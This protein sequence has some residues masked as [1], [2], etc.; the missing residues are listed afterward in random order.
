MAVAEGITLDKI[1]LVVGVTGH[2]NI[3][4]ADE[5]PLR[6]AFGGILAELAERYPHTPLLVLSGLAAGADVLAAEEAL[7]RGI[8]VIAC[9]PM[10][11][12][13]YENDFN[14]AERERFRAILPRCA[15]KPVV[16]Q[17]GDRRSGYVA[18]GLFITRYSHVLVAFWDGLEGRGRGGTADVVQTRLT[19]ESAQPDG[20]AVIPYLPDVGPVYHI[21]T[22]HDGVDRPADSFAVHRLY[23]RKFGDDLTVARDFEAALAHLDTYDADLGRAPDTRTATLHALHERTD[24]VAN[25]LQKRTN[26][27]LGLLYIILFFAATA[28]ITTENLAYK[29]FGILVT[30]G[31]YFLARKNDYE[32]RY[33]DYRALAEGLRVQEAWYCGGLRNELVDVFYL[34]M[35]QSEL[36]W[37]RMALR[38]AFLLFCEPGVAPAEAPDP[39]VCEDWVSGQ[40]EYF[41]FK[42][43]DQ[44]ARHK[45]L[46]T[47]STVALVAGGAISLAAFIAYVVH[48]HYTLAGAFWDPNNPFWDQNWAWSV[49]RLMTVPLPLAALV[50]TLLWQYGE[51]RNYAAN[52]RRYQRMYIVFERASE[53]LE[54]IGARDTPEALAVI[55]D[56]GEEALIEHADWLLA[57]RDR[58]LS[59]AHA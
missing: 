6:A 11:V 43:R 56:L 50:S 40:V 57:R 23:P 55:H 1:P 27:F 21:V 34:R 49:G 35:Q 3:A 9:L 48:G 36:Q 2:R 10:D 33:Q 59:L 4:S 16:S 52:A 20:V 25:T 22:P 51:K 53:H 45:V 29:L 26:F 28:Q 44:A 30:L 15:R 18:T 17:S 32:N 37:I 58:P 24:A 47:I 54:K 5:A 12:A 8:P 39:K 38:C 13:E 14:E 7:A 42:R 41:E 31:V 46:T 19:G